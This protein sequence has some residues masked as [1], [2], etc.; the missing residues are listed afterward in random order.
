MPSSAQIRLGACKIEMLRCPVYQGAGLFLIA[1]LDA[2]TL[3]NALTSD[4]NDRCGDRIGQFGIGCRNSRDAQFANSAAHLDDLRIRRAH[5]R[6]R[7]GATCN[8][9]AI[10]IENWM[11]AVV[12]SDRSSYCS[13]R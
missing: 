7:E 8:L 3:D 5:N 11:P 2:S 13:F 12:T 6:A 1:T 9:L 10:V 4:A